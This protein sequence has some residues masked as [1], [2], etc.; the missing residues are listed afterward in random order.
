MSFTKTVVHPS[1]L[2]R[3]KVNVMTYMCTHVQKGLHHVTIPKHTEGGCVSQQNTLQ[4]HYRL[5]SESCPTFG[6]RQHQNV[7][8][9]GVRGNGG[10]GVDWS[11]HPVSLELHLHSSCWDRAYELLLPLHTTREFVF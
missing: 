4:T 11:N 7:P 6:P 1:C 8:L 5:R 3:N 10:R 2:F 9:C